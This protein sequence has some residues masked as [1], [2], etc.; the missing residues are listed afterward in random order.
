MLCRQVF[1]ALN[2]NWDA[3][4]KKLKASSQTHVAGYVEG[5]GKAGHVACNM[6]SLCS[7]CPPSF[8]G[9]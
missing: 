8:F 4:E 5:S 6:P 7:G 3:G 2:I 9:G 1:S